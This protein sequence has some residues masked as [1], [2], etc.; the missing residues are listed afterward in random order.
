MS[1]EVLVSRRSVVVS[2]LAAICVF[3]SVAFAPHADARLRPLKPKFDD[4]SL[5]WAG[6]YVL[7]P[8]GQKVTQ[9][10]GTTYVPKLRLLPP[11]QAASWV[12]IGG[13]TGTDLIQAGVAFGQLDGYY[14]WFERLPES[15]QGVYSGC[16]GDNNCTVVPGDRIDMDIRNTGGDNWRISLVNV[17]KW[18]WSMNTAYKST[19][20]SAEWIFEAPSYF[21]VYTVPP[22]VP[23]AQFLNNR[24]T[25]NGQ[26]KALKQS[27]ATR[28][29]F[30]LIVAKISSTSDVRAD[31]GFQVCPYVQTCP[32]P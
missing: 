31:S 3:V 24:Y 27:E 23:H 1:K 17:G 26:T 12:G 16:V 15:I 20:S 2:C 28:T 21:G 30:S 7:P 6:Y 10:S 9:V 8:A 18:S 14:I 22:R 4:D 25:V 32:K 13:A 19:F 11:T 5:N 29:A